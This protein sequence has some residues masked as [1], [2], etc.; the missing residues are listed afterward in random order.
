MKHSTLKKTKI[1]WMQ[2]TLPP[3]HLQGPTIRL[4]TRVITS[5]RAFHKYKCK[6]NHAVALINNKT[7]SLLNTGSCYCYRLAFTS[8]AACWPLRI[9]RMCYFFH[10]GT[11]VFD[12]LFYFVNDFQYPFQLFTF[13]IHIL[14]SC[15]VCTGTFIVSLGAIRLVRFHLSSVFWLVNSIC[16][17]SVILSF[18][19]MVLSILQGI[20]FQALYF[21]SG[22]L[23]F[24]VVIWY[25]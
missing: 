5:L 6:N 13:T 1:L 10:I 20:F 24:P 18:F 22:S 16:P 21:S 12:L 4:H 8:G 7:T 19:P 17:L 25:S 23:F 11:V 9:W 15:F 2:P 3:G 14:H